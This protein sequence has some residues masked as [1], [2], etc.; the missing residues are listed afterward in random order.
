MIAENDVHDF[1]K[2]DKHTKIGEILRKTSLDEIPQLW[3]IAT[4]KMSFIGPRPWI[5]DY[6][7]NM[8]TYKDIDIALG[9]DLQ[10]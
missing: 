3:S 2:A 8:M 6:F 9:Q 4:A 7:N 10:D 5:P 1:S